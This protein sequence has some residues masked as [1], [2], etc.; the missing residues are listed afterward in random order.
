MNEDWRSDGRRK[1]PREIAVIMSLCKHCKQT[2]VPPG[3]VQD[4]L[5]SRKH[6][7]KAIE[8]A[9]AGMDETSG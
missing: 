5:L 4:F 1:G 8:P 2:I 3:Q 9:E 6:G 7:M